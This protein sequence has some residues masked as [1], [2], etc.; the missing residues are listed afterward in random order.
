MHPVFHVSQLRRCLRV[1]EKECVPEEE[2]DLQIDL[3]YQ[4]V[5]VKI[6]DTV[7]K[8]TRNSKVQICR[9]QWSRHGVEEATWE[10]ADALKKEFPHLFRSYPNLE[11]EIHFKWCR[12]V[13]PIFLSYL[14]CI[15]N[16][17]L[18]NLLNL[19]RRSSS[20]SPPPDFPPSRHRAISSSFSAEP[21]IPFPFPPAPPS[22]RITIVSRSVTCAYPAA[23]VAA[24]RVSPLFFSH[25]LFKSILF[26]SS[27]SP[28]CL[29][30]LLCN[31]TIFLCNARKIE[32]TV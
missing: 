22:R 28:T 24:A 6:L 26:L 10:R 11:D 32:E 17:S 13:T 19:F 18:K 3:R 16:H 29:F 4:E 8:R 21:P 25:I 15:T 20:R 27:N 31:V 30:K 2:I 7:T 5:P 1:P 14:N 23:I 12:F 9:V